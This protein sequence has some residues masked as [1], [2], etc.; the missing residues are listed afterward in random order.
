L[1]EQKALTKKVDASRLGSGFDDIDE[2]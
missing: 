2:F 1:P